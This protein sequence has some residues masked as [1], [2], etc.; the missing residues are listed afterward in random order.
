[1]FVD[2]LP[3]NVQGAVEIG[4]VG[5][6]FV[7]VEQAVGELEAMFGLTLRPVTP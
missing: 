3:S 2:D 4:M 5:V 6:R 1:V 7:G